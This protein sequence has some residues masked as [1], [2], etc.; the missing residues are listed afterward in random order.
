[1]IKAL[2][3]Q[4]KAY[5]RQIITLVETLAKGSAVKGPTP[6]EKKKF[7]NLIVI[8]FLDPYRQVKKRDKFI[9]RKRG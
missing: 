2:V 3:T 1:L 9:S 6:E 5:S 4:N 7:H 8:Y